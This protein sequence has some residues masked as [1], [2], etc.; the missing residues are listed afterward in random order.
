MGS[1][2]VKAASAVGTETTSQRSV[3]LKDQVGT[4]R[5]WA[6]VTYEARGMAVST[7]L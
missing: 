7:N 3:F 2:L 4:D 6:F 5:G 1:A